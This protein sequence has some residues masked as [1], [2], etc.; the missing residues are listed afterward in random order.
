MDFRQKIKQ[1]F[2]LSL[3]RG[4]DIL[5]AM[6]SV[7]V[8]MGYDM[9]REANSDNARIK[10][11][12]ANPGA[13]YPLARAWIRSRFENRKIL[14]KDLWPVKAL[15]GWGIDTDI[16]KEQIY[17]YWGIY[18]YQFHACTEAGVVAMQSWNRKGM[19]F[20][21]YSNFFEFIPEDELLKCRENPKHKPATVLMSE[22]ESGK[23]YEL[24][25]S[26]F[27]GMP[28]IRYRLGHLIS[29]TALADEDAH[30]NI[31]HM[32]FEGRADEVIDIAGFARLSEKTIAQA[33]ADTDL[34]CVDWVARKEFK[35]GQP[36][37]HLYMELSDTNTPAEVGY[38][39]HSNL[40]TIDPFYSDLDSMMEIKP[41]E[42]TLLR[43]GTYSD[44][45]TQKFEGG[46]DLYQ[47][48]PSRMSSSQEV[49]ETLI[50][51]ST[52]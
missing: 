50:E 5:F 37:L 46:S 30:I 38:E 14:P 19:V 4:V 10:D 23:R 40:K 28:F 22:V 35:D 26:S 3:T 36:K 12:M 6:T 9:G 49:I 17:K 44:F 39:V 51:I 20:Q 31:P 1:G 11:H 8:K 21:P 16:L 13:L 15:I 24:V 27:N 43:P 52:R 34:G 33:I 47:R 32:A 45:Y 42:V 2:E 41:V 48:T 7:L 29:I 25:I 18:P